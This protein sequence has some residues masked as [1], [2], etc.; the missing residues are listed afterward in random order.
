MR[1]QVAIAVKEQEYARRLADYVR[2]SPIGEQWQLTVFTHPDAFVQYLRSGYPVDLVAAQP[3]MLSAASD[4]LGKVPVAALVTARGQCPEYEEIRQYQPLP[5]LLRSLSALYAGAS[6][7][8]AHRGAEG[9]GSSVIAVY[10]AS[11]GVGKTTLSL[12]LMETAAA[13]GCRAFYLNLERWSAWHYKLDGG[14]LEVGGEG[15]HQG[16]GLSQLLY[17]LKS[18][19][20]RA[21]DWLLKHRK[22]HP[23]FKGDYLLPCS[24]QEDRLAL[25]AAD[26]E[27]I[28]KAISA[29]GQY[30]LIVVDL[31]EGTDELHMT[32][33]ERS[34]QIIWLLTDDPSVRRKAELAYRYAEQRWQG[35]FEAVERRFQFVVNRCSTERVPTADGGRFGAKHPI[36]AELPEQESEGRRKSGGA[37]IASP[38]YK[39]AVERLFRFL[40]EEEGAK[41]LVHR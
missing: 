36:A 38:V 12:Q 4:S 25:S 28:V 29:T 24:N 19:P 41:P 14:E 9:D 30:D 22:R 10:S 21:G 32:I 26:A 23:R 13:K 34:D 39:A 15:H 3:S 40:I 31:D 6:G 11:G 20:E 7:G 2:N 1:L 8:K 18:Q 5:E 35:R 16:E 17:V 37:I 33:C 27:A